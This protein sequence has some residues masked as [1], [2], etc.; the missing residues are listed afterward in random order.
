MKLPPT[1]LLAVIAVAW[2]ASWAWRGH[3]AAE[4]GVELARLARPGDIRMI[5]SETCPYCLAARQWM[6]Q[7]GV[8]FGECFIERD[9]ACAEDFQAQGAV[10]T[11]TLVVRGQRVIGFDRARLMEIL[12]QPSRVGNAGSAALPTRLGGGGK[13]RHVHIEVDAGFSRA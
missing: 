10:G 5:S 6:T 12:K 1:S 8:P 13:R 2:L 3:V 7:Q 11:P 9:A 4:D